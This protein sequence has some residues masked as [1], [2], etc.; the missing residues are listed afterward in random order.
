MR[1]VAEE[2]PA[3][4]IDRRPREPAIAWAHVC[5]RHAAGEVRV[6]LRDQVA[7]AE[8]LRDEE[9][10]VGG[11]RVAN[12]AVGSAAGYQIAREADKSAEHDIN[13]AGKEAVENIDTETLK[14]LK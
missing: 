11:S 4:R 8:L 12:A 9:G 5:R 13:K 3:P 2:K 6:E 10:A 14:V 7:V 1:E